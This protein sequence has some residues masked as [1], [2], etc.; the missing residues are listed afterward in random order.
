[1]H[2]FMKE[3]RLYVFIII[4]MKAVYYYYEEEYDIVY[5]SVLLYMNDFIAVVMLLEALE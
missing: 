4:I 2:K 5:E 1:M 3:R